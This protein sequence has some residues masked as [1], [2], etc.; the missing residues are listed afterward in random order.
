MQRAMQKDG[1]KVKDGG[2]VCFVDV[3]DI[4]GLSDTDVLYLVGG[5]LYGLVR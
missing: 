2:H 1:I 5:L 3:D 4:I